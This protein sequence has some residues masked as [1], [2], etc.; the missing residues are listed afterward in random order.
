[1]ADFEHNYMTVNGFRTHFLEAGEGDP[2]VLLHGGEFGASAELAWERIIPLLSK[3]F[4]IIAPDVLGFGESAKVHDF[5]EGRIMRIR[6]VADLLSEL[7]IE[8]AY[9]A[10]NSMGGQMLIVDQSADAPLLNVEK[11]IIICG[12]GD[13]IPNE[14]MAAL[15]DYDATVEAMRKVVVGLFHNESFHNDKEYVQ[16][17]YESSIQPGAWEAVAAARFRRPHWDG[18][19]PKEAPVLANIS[20]PTLVLEGEF[21]K[22]KPKGWSSEVAGLIPGAEARIVSG[23]GHCPQIEVPE[24]AAEIFFEFFQAD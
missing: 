2:L 13:I 18:S 3:R 6:Q 4:H 11:Q 24:L 15:Q 9:F 14:H 17:R 5:T 19:G 22:L 1:V 16:R 20:V 12:G 10:G 21:D 7:G 23:S 8:S